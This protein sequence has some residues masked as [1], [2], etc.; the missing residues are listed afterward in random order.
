MELPQPVPVPPLIP[1]P[2][3]TA[4]TQA[5]CLKFILIKIHPFVFCLEIRTPFLYRH[6]RSKLPAETDPRAILEKARLWPFMWCGASCRGQAVGPKWVTL[7]GQVTVLVTDS[8]DCQF[9]V[10]RF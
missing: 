8:C 4:I 10:F 2:T 7:H 1:I 6:I 5:Q 9:E 3:A